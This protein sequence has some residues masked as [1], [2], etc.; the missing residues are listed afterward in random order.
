MVDIR[1]SLTNIEI[2]PPIETQSDCNASVLIINEK[3]LDESNPLYGCFCS[4]CSLQA[5]G[6]IKPPAPFSLDDADLLVYGQQ[7][8]F[9]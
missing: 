8:S 1:K 9:I 2:N 4:I 3:H 7:K 5:K 6:K